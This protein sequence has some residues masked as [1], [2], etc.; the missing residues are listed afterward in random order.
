MRRL[1]PSAPVSGFRRH[2]RGAVDSITSILLIVFIR[3]TRPG[4]RLIGPCRVRATRQPTQLSQPASRWRRPC[5]RIGPSPRQ[6]LRPG[7]IDRRRAVLPARHESRSKTTTSILS[8]NTEDIRATRHRA[9]PDLVPVQGGDSEG[10]GT[11]SSTRG[12]GPPARSRSLPLFDVGP[13]TRSSVC[14]EHSR[15]SLFRACLLVRSLVD[16]FEDEGESP[17]ARF[18][19]ALFALNQSSGPPALPLRRRC[20][21]WPDVAC[22]GLFFSRRYAACGKRR[23]NDGIPA[24]LALVMLMRMKLALVWSVA[25]FSLCEVRLPFVVCGDAQAGPL[26]DALR[27]SPAEIRDLGISRR[28]KS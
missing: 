27:F 9:A 2:R 22:G 25:V 4:S 24:L 16:G 18:R 11:A 28:E 5:L 7:V 8:N 20:D 6:K 23:G 1:P 17:D 19:A 3:C 26:I 21:F 14:R 15:R 13:A 12:G 10:T